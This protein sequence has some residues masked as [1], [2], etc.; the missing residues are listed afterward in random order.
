MLTCDVTVQQKILQALKCVSNEIAI[1]KILLLKISASNLCE[2]MFSIN[3]E[4]WHM[5]YTIQSTVKTN[6]PDGRWRFELHTKSTSE[7]MKYLLF[8]YGKLY[9]KIKSITWGNWKKI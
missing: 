5:F 4:N 1:N 9:T 2:Y 8:S 6:S 7:I 3:C